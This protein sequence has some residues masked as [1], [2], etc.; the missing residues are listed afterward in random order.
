MLA[1]YDGGEGLERD[2]ATESA[3]WLEGQ[4]LHVR[5]R[6]KGQYR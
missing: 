2:G 3:S 6:R 1:M 4:A 5:T